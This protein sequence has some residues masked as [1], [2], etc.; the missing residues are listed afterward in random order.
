VK[1]M[2]VTQASGK[3]TTLRPASQSGYIVHKSTWDELKKSRPT[4]NGAPLIRPGT[5]KILAGLPDV[6]RYRGINGNTE[7]EHIELTFDR[8]H[9][10]LYL[11]ITK[12]KNVRWHKSEYFA[13]FNLQN[14]EVTWAANQMSSALT[15]DRSHTNFQGIDT[16]QNFLTGELDRDGL[17]KFSKILTGRARLKLY[18]GIREIKNIP[19]VGACIAF[20]AINASADLWRWNWWDNPEL[21]DRPCIT[22]RD[23]RFDSKGS[24]Y[25]Y[26]DDLHYPYDD[27]DGRLIFPFWLPNSDKGFV[28]ESLTYPLGG[29]S[30]D[31]FS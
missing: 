26:R 21:F 5:N 6:Y 12:Y 23:V 13:W 25:I 22:G 30:L 1:E 10:L 3:V 15:H 8:Q 7:P 31:K 16:C 20:Q 11:N 2:T 28:L 29:Q 24:P 14:A 27:F 17:P 19:G 18:N 4:K 9:Y